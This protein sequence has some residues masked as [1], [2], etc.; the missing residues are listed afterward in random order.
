MGQVSQMKKNI[1]N[2]SSG[3]YRGGESTSKIG[4]KYTVDST[5]KPGQWLVAFIQNSFV[6]CEY[7]PE[8]KEPWRIVPYEVGDEK[9]P[10]EELD[11]VCERRFVEHLLSGELLVQVGIDGD[12]KAKIQSGIQSS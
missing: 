11:H 10:G 8:G 4:D 12:W 1:P 3:Y 6:Y 7:L 2:L 5:L 9:L